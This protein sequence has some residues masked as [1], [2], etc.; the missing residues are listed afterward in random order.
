MYLVDTNVWLEHLLNQTKAQKA[1]RFITELDAALLSMSHFS[2]HSICVILSRQKRAAKLDQFIN[3]LFIQ[4]HVVLRTIPAA[5]LKSV[6]AAMQAQRL[7]FDDA[8]QYVIAKRDGLTLVSFD[9]DFDHTDLPRQTPAQVLV[10]LPPPTA[11][12]ES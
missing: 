11:S 9:G 1:F 5:G 12:G 2:L 10:A 7:D 3:D 6:T 8:Y 4:S